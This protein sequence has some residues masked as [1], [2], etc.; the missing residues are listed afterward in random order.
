MERGSAPKMTAQREERTEKTAAAGRVIRVGKKGIVRRDERD[1]EEV[2]GE[3]EAGKEVIAAERER[4]TVREKGMNINEENMTKKRKIMTGR[5]NTKERETRKENK[6]TREK[7]NRKT[8]G[9]ENTR[10]TTKRREKIM[11]E[12]EKKTTRENTRGKEMTKTDTAAGRGAGAA[13]RGAGAA[14]TEATTTP[15][16][17]TRGTSTCRD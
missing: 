2:M 12:K 10:E 13:G 14:D 8:S 5:E 6:S 3:E 1:A 11:K 4:E 7:E 15:G 16:K 9:K 17:R